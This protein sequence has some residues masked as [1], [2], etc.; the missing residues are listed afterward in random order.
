[1]IQSG[2]KVGGKNNGKG[3]GGKGKGK[4][5]KGKGKGN[6]KGSN[7]GGSLSRSDDIIFHEL[8]PSKLPEKVTR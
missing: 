4:G 1:M 6:G 2:E 8:P 7:G 3:G 5:G